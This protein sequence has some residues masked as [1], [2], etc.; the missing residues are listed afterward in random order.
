MAAAAERKSSARYR[1]MAHP[2]ESQ[3][4]PANGTPIGSR[5]AAFVRKPNTKNGKVGRSTIAA[6][7]S[8]PS[9]RN[10]TPS[11]SERG[12]PGGRGRRERGPGVPAGV[13]TTVGRE[14]SPRAGT[15][16]GGRR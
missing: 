4:S 14:M 5:I 3:A 8:E 9:T 16:R 15:P 11:G 2:M 6:V 1:A 10:G 12:Q 13:R 7:E